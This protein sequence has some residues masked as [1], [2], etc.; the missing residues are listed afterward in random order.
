MKSRT[1][2]ITISATSLIVIL[3]SI[4][5]YFEIVVPHNTLRDLEWWEQASAEEQRQVAHQILRYPVGN[6]H[7]AF[8]ILTE[9][10]N[11][12]SIPYLLNGLKWYEFFNRGEDFILYSRDHCLDALRKI[13]GKDLGTKYTDWKDIDTY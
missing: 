7:D 13:T 6:H 9:F 10:G 12:E 5:V 11:S 8:L 3:L 1:L 4:F 2:K